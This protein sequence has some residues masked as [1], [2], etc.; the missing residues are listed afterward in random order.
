MLKARI[1]A[2]NPEA[3]L[4]SYAQ[5][6]RDFSWAEAEKEFAWHKTGRLNIAYEA[7][8]RWAEDPEKRDQKALIFEKG[9]EINSFSYIDLKELSCQWANV[10]AKYGIKTGDRLFILLPPCPEIYLTILACSRLGAIF[11]PLY[12]TLGIDE[13]EVRVKNGNPRGILTHPD[14]AERL[15]LESM[16]SIE[17]VFFTEGPLPALF[18]SEVLVGNHLNQMSKE[19]EPKWLT[20]NTPLYLIYTSG[21]TGPPKGVVHAHQDMVGQLMTARY[22]LDIR[23]ETILWT[24]GDPAWIT[25]TVY[26]TFAPWLCG[27]TTVV[28][29][30]Q[31]SAST[32]YRTLERHQVSVWYTT[33]ITIKKLME[34][35]DDLPTRY[36]FSHLRHI[37]TVGQ[38]LTPELFYWVQQNLKLSPHNTWWMSETGMICLANFPSMDIKVGSIGKPVP[39]IEVAILDENGNPL[40]ILTMGELALKIPWPSLMAGLWRDEGRYQDYF[41]FK[42]WFMTGDMTIQDEEGYFYHQGRMDDLIKVEDKLIGPYE[43]EHILCRHPAVREAAVISKSTEPDRPHLKAFITVD[44]GY[45]PSNR[46]NQEI[47]AFLKANLSPDTPLKEIDFLDALPRT[48][49]GKLLRRV[50]RAHELGLP[51]G[52]P[53]HMKD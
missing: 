16:G 9:K 33:P 49:T 31:F 11:C 45:V 13:L 51:S 2:E 39:G 19:L 6:Y 4:K 15:P 20:G 46:L 3:N 47:K 10:L 52:D 32:W 25:G 40:P 12:S 37:A 22:G 27:A 42:D 1:K 36:D 50:L 7:I 41:R 30:I 5:T 18:R 17:H 28:Q 35:G 26:G 8:D 24:D 29:G 23:E 34:A 53:S 48:S 38:A 43:I 21:S 14:L 44:T